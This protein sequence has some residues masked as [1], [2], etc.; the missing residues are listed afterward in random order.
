MRAIYLRLRALVREETGRCSGGAKKG[1]EMKRDTMNARLAKVSWGLAAFALLAS[2]TWSSTAQAVTIYMAQELWS[3]DTLLKWEDG[4]LTTVGNTGWGDVRGLAYDHSTDELYGVSRMNGPRLIT[5][6]RGSG[7]GTAVSSNYF[8]PLDSNSA[9]LD[10][11]AS[12]DMWGLGHTG[13][14]TKVDELCEVDKVSGIATVVGNY[15]ADVDFLSGFAIDHSDGTLYGSGYS[16]ELYTIDSSGT[17]VTYLGTISGTNGGVARIAFEHSTGTMY[18][19]TNRN[20]LVTIDLGTLVGT[21]LDQFSGAQIYSITVE[22]EGTPQF[23]MGVEGSCPGEITVT[24]TGATPNAPVAVIYSPDL[25]S[26]TVP[27]GPCMGTELDVRHPTVATIESADAQG[28]VEIT[29]RVPARGCGFYLQSVD[30]ATCT[31]SNTVQ[32]P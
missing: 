3:N 8:L 30:G 4:A 12:G 5:I 31:T 25:G 23:S 16:G 18:G 24:V 26:F 13:D 14:Q 19:I 29:R 1:Y 32:I 17:F 7:V 22:G 28:V 20:Q 6:D 10:V 21:P 9:E 27:A 15:G 2:L 11:D